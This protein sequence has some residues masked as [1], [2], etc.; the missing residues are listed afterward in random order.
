M[1]LSKLA[2][3]VQLAYI[4]H[5]KKKAEHIATSEVQNLL[6]DLQGRTLIEVS[7]T[8]AE[9]E[10]LNLGVDESILEE[11][12]AQKTTVSLDITKIEP[13]R[14]HFNTQLVDALKIPLTDPDY[15]DFIVA[16]VDKMPRGSLIALQQELHFHLNLAA[17]T[18]L[19]A[20]PALS[21]KQ[22]GIDKA[23]RKTMV[24][25]NKHIMQ[26]YTD[27][28][29]A[30][31][32]HETMSINLADL[33]N[34]LD[35][36]RK[37][38]TPLAHKILHQKIEEE[39]GVHI[40]KDLI[41]E[42]KHIAET[43]TATAN[44]LIHTDNSSG[45]ATWIEGSEVTA[46]DRDIGIKH[47]APRNIITHSIDR[48]TGDVKS[49]PQKR[50]QVRIP[51]LDAKKKK[52]T[53]LEHIHDVKNKI[54]HIADKYMGAIPAHPIKAFVYN[55]FTSIAHTSDEMMGKN[56]QTQGAKHILHGA[57]SY[58]KEAFKA[59]K[60]LCFVQN[61][62][63]NGFGS[64]LSYA[65]GGLRREAAL[66]ADIA[67][68]HT[69]YPS[70]KPS[71]QLLYKSALDKYTKFLNSPDL[72]KNKF[73]SDTTL[74]H[75]AAV[76]ISNI[77]SRLASI[78]YKTPAGPDDVLANVNAC[79]RNLIINDS[80]FIH[81]FSKLA[82]TLSVFLEPY[83]MGGCKSA[84]ER[85][86]AINGRVTILDSLL[87]TPEEQLNDDQKQLIKAL[88]DLAQSNTSANI[89]QLKSAL[90][91][92][93]NNAGLQTAM[94]L[95]SLVDQGG[96]A[97]GMVKLGPT[98][99]GNYF[100]DAEL[101][102][103]HQSKSDTM[104][105]HKG[106]IDYMEIACTKPLEVRAINEVIQA[107]LDQQI[108][109]YS[110]TFGRLKEREFLKLQ[111]LLS[112]NP[113]FEKITTA[114]KDNYEY[115]NLS[116]D[117]V[118]ALKV[119]L[120]AKIDGIDGETEEKKLF[121]KIAHT[122]VEN[123]ATG[124][125]NFV[126]E[127][128]P[129]EDA[130]DDLYKG[131]L[132]YKTAHLEQIQEYIAKHGLDQVTEDSP[133]F[134]R[135]KFIEYC[136]TRRFDS[137]QI[138]ESGDS[139]K[140][141]PK[142][143]TKSLEALFGA[144]GA[145]LY[146]LALE[147]ER[148]SKEYM[149]AVFHSSTTYYSGEKWVER[150]VVIVAGP[151]ASGKSFAAQAAVQA[152]NDY[153]LKYPQPNKALQP[154][155]YVVAIDGGVAREVSQMRKL[156]IRVANDLG[157]TGISD[158]HNQSE[159]LGDVKKC[160]QNAVFQTKDLG[161]VIPETFSNPLKVRTLHKK[162]SSLE[163]AKVVFSRVDGAD[164]ETFREVVSFMGSRR[165]WKTDQFGEQLE[166]DLNS[167]R[168]LCESKGYGKKGFFWGRE[169]S[170]YAEEYFRK[171]DPNLLSL[172]ITNDLILLKPNPKATPASTKK[173]QW[174]IA[175]ENDENVIKVSKATYQKWLTASGVTPLEEFMKTNSV[176]LIATTAEQGIQEAQK[177]IKEALSKNRNPEVHK[178]LVNALKAI[179][180][181]NGALNSPTAVDIAL[182]QIEALQQ[183]PLFHT[184]SSDVKEAL[185]E[186]HLQLE[187]RFRE[188]AIVAAIKQYRTLEETYETQAEEWLEQQEEQNTLFKNLNAERH[189]RA[190]LI[191][192][193]AKL[194]AMSI[195]QL[196]E[197]FLS[198]NKKSA[199]ALKAPMVEMGK[200]CKA[201]IELYTEQKVKISE[202]L[203]ALPKKEE[204]R[205]KPY[206]ED[207]EIH[208]EELIEALTEIT[209]T[210][211]EVLILAQKR[212]EGDKRSSKSI[213]R[214]GLLESINAA[215]KDDKEVQLASMFHLTHKDV[216]L[217]STTPDPDIDDEADTNL[218]HNATLYNK[219]DKLAANKQRVYQVSS[220]AQSIGTF[221]ER[222]LD[223]SATGVTPDQTAIPHTR[224]VATKPP[225]GS[226]ESSTSIRDKKIIYS[227]AL[228][229]Q[230]LGKLESPPTK[231]NPLT[232]E[233]ASKEELQFLYIALLLVG[234]NKQMS[235]GP[236]ALRV[237]SICFDPSKESISRFSSDSCYSKHFK[238]NPIVEP[239]LSDFGKLLK[240]RAVHNKEQASLVKDLSDIT[241]K[242]KKRLDAIAEAPEADGPS[243]TT[244]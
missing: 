86:Q 207:V 6:I 189:L 28:L 140:D 134:F 87:S 8:K 165:A 14:R 114:T 149:D 138:P 24:E 103:L 154:G 25:L 83:S 56:K 227:F 163:N 107:K 74:G 33:N 22:E 85:A 177:I 231:A 173:S 58:N 234:K 124:N 84:N 88:R 181:K 191:K 9:L 97:K 190:P 92:A 79:L 220:A 64:T 3:D 108:S 110:M 170:L 204:L 202:L 20:V 155:N 67:L 214:E 238:N 112:A 105:A 95:I 60:P 31:F 148:F 12:A 27:A 82:Q 117:E 183:S 208:R 65:E 229:T 132:D 37:Q 137:Y 51:S 164:P 93:Y 35:I 195:P 123:S 50:M 199:D 192:S 10:T 36:A 222:H 172:L 211:D 209:D 2:K 119:A 40:T 62:P 18:Y 102:N 78:A 23:H 81:K 215:Q 96:A 168:S 151:S 179:S 133:D 16:T 187:A 19:K 30:S 131:I 169:G 160:V 146:L 118:Q 94:S 174:T 239:I 144:E 221:V 244:H 57:H 68:M 45:L 5:L 21:G 47:L 196:N 228:A 125:D 52:T 201:L 115:L 205:G 135:K 158:L 109:K 122:L 69:L 203:E 197:A 17:R 243:F 147:E 167:V 230:L 29:K 43:T 159:I 98:L 70:L 194:D 73:F 219:V 157:F 233:G 235:F 236:E 59:G 89:I 63:V 7:V 237:R 41:K 46:H 186:L 193:F 72:L 242:F 150:P 111:E 145:K 210:L 171:Q 217:H 75:E 44:N 1:T 156:V 26:V 49:H 226:A 166:L 232:L 80:H 120:R 32:N 161:V 143:A 180:P 71:E 101:S 129:S 127:R 223:K 216:D 241:S 136:L 126:T 130:R 224:F 54:T 188:V 106:L 240:D 99:N 53:D 198:L 104:Q 178:M 213:E 212:I 128:L 76:Q 175:S 121:M 176:T 218:S 90:N 162:V 206:R 15:S 225:R 77:K 38:I 66:M 13:I 152:A 142:E 185:S 42:A 11:L 113:D 116:Q 184:A 4:N 48:N 100:E 34:K 182:I 55:L 61:I 141:D 153:L 200:Q 139:R 91:T 39:T